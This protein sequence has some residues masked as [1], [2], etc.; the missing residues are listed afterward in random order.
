M[1]IAIFSDTASPQKNGVAQSIERQVRILQEH[2]HTAFVVSSS[3]FDVET[4]LSDRSILST[5]DHRYA[6]RLPNRPKKDFGRLPE[7][8]MAHLH[9]PFAYGI[10]G[11]MEAQRRQLP[12][13]YTHHTN[14]DHYLPYVPLASN[15][16]GRM[17]YRRAYRL[18]LNRLQAIICPSDAAMRQIEHLTH[19][20]HRP[21]ISVMH[22]PVFGVS[23]EDA[24][25]NGGRILDICCVGRLS[26]EK[27]IFLMADVLKRVLRN[28]PQTKIAIVGDGKDRG[29]FEKMFSENE[30][31][32]ISFKGE[33][34]HTDV[35]GILARSRVFFQP[36]ISETQGLVVQESW[37]VGTP[38][39]LAESP[40]AREFLIAGKNG[41]MAP[42]STVGLSTL[43][44]SVL[45]EGMDEVE[46]LREY[47]VSSIAS[48][49]PDVW[50]KRYKHILDKVST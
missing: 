2:G 28:R 49:S 22:T 19:R 7:F 30:R 45:S 16:L 27:N 14:F 38:V 8:D 48:F 12:C 37:S 34:P 4:K 46:G 40:A 36:S 20:Q 11:F 32:Q 18:F 33:I 47:C 39:V 42:A 23:T 26:V 15:A 5:R 13:I 6:L 17:V 29:A 31:R 21:H 43:L 25:L 9:T 44:L 41:W 35:L 3:A 1:R 10:L 50:Y 24:L